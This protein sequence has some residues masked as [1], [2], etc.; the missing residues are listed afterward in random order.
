MDV[1]YIL[2]EETTTDQHCSSLGCS[3]GPYHVTKTIPGQSDLKRHMKKR[4]KH[5][6]LV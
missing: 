3:E 4:S 1:T 2:S 6:F 5:L